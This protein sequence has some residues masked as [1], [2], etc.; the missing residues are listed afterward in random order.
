MG[1]RNTILSCRWADY[2]G[3]KGGWGIEIGMCVVSESTNLDRINRIFR[4]DE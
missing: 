4:I 1:A 3:M 2:S